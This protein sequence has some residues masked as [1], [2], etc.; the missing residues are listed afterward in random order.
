MIVLMLAGPAAASRTRQGAARRVS[1]ADAPSPRMTSLV[2]ALAADDVSARAAKRIQS[3]YAAA[4]GPGAAADAILELV[5][6]KRAPAPAPESE[7]TFA[8]L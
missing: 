2:R 8:T 5:V 3:I 4:D 7:A 6:E 1:Q